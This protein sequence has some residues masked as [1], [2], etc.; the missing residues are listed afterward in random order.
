MML[1]TRGTRRLVEAATIDRMQQE[2]MEAE[3][4]EYCVCVYASDPCRNMREV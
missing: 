1:I 4:Q 2:R 3:M